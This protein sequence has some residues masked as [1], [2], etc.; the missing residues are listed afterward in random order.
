MY[1]IICLEIH[2]QTGYSGTLQNVPVGVPF[3]ELEG[4]SQCSQKSSTGNVTL[5]T[6]VQ[7]IV[8]QFFIM[9][10]LILSSTFVSPNKR[11]NHSFRAIMIS[12]GPRTKI[13]RQF[14]KTGAV[15]PFGFP[16]M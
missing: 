14:F 7:I 5:A 8:L 10:V 15:T 16:L 6:T 13:V 11:F 1:N 12:L 3:K 9:S 4:T 2:L